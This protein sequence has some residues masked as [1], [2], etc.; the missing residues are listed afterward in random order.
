MGH[1]KRGRHSVQRNSEREKN[2]TAD[3]KRGR[4]KGRAREKKIQGQMNRWM[5][6][7]KQAQTEHGC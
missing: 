7:E 3:W 2:V 6:E 4:E 1:R 5:K